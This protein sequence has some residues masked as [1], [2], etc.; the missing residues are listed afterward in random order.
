MHVS[1]NPE[2]L[3]DGINRLRTDWGF[4]NDLTTFMCENAALLD[5]L[6]VFCAQIVELKTSEDAYS[7]LKIF[8]ENNQHRTKTA[9]KLR[10]RRL[11]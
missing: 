1:N 11:D 5:S 8:K 9:L 4:K 10:E 2:N 6:D 7:Y 3:I